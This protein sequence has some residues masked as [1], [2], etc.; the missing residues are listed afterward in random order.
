MPRPPRWSCLILNTC[1][2]QLEGEQLEGEKSEDG[3]TEV[4]EFEVDQT[5]EQDDDQNGLLDPQPFAPF[6]KCSGVAMYTSLVHTIKAIKMMKIIIML[7]KMILK[8]MI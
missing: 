7:F 1:Q 4:D 5:E 3:Q 6:Q 8:S 2:S